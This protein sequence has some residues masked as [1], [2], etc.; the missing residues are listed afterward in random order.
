M[1]MPNSMSVCLPKSVCMARM[2]NS[3][4]MLKSVCFA[5]ADV[6]VYAEVEPGRL[7]DCVYAEAECKVDYLKSARELGLAR[8]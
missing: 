5:E 3:A 4:T 1:C 2:S 6:C 8:I 7:V